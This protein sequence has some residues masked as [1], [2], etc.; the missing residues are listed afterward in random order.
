MNP[1]A[2]YAISAP[3]AAV[4]VHYRV[5]HVSRATV[6][7]ALL[8]SLGA[9]LAVLLGVN[10]A[11][12]RPVLKT[13]VATETI[14]IVPYR[15]EE[16]EEPPLVPPDTAARPAD[17]APLVPTRPDTPSV[18][19]PDDFV[20]PLDLSSLVERPKS[21][22]N[23]TAI[24]AS[25]T[26]TGPVRPGEP[27]FNPGDLHRS[28]VPLSQPPPTY[29]HALRREA[30]TATVVVEFIVTSS[31]TVTNAQPVNSTHPGFNDAAVAGVSKWKF[32]AGMRDGRYVNTRMQ[33]P[34]LFRITDEP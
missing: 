17:I 5:S 7:V 24:P 9:H 31:G 25:F 12:P 6:A 3:G 1:L 14:H 26:R 4:P 19:R 34:I 16:I 18:P 32:R 33:V 30:L 29:P 10:P 11:K 13:K 15:P 27:I 8:V 2:G 23:L 22:E 28:P 21:D 20:Q